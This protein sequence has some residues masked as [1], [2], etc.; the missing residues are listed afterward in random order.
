MKRR[1]V[2]LTGHPAGFKLHFLD[3]P[4]FGR[5]I[6]PIEGRVTHVVEVRLEE[7]E[8][9]EN[10]LKRFKKVVQN[11]GL[12]SEMKKREFYEK[13]SDRRK[14]KEAAAR[15]KARRRQMKFRGD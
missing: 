8:P 1:P 7:N 2:R 3:D 6:P 13:P 5:R 4:L 9:I 12:I 11:S 10:A 14:K 15:K